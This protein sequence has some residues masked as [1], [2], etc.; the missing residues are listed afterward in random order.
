MKPHYRLRAWQEA[1]CLANQVY[2]WSA[3]FPVDERFGLTAQIRR[4]AVSVASNIAEGAGRGSPNELRQFLR[5]A[6]GSLVEIDTQ[7]LLAINLGFKEPDQSLADQIEKTG[8]LI[9]GLINSI[10]RQ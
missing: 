7:Y 1:M 9:T 5:I 6:R 8:R 10:G 4:A 3:D 2:S